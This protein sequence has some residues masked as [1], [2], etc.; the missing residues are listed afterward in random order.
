MSNRPRI[1]VIDIETAP[2]VGNVWGLYD[3]NVGINQIE[4]K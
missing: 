3:Q 4:K 2:I 1:G